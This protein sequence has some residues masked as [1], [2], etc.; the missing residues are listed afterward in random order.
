MRRPIRITHAHTS[1]VALSQKRLP[2][3]AGVDN[4]LC[5]SPSVTSCSVDPWQPHDGSLGTIPGF[6]GRRRLQSGLVD[7]FDIRNELIDW[8]L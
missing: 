1:V 8:C 7:T 2:I 6:W 5:V 3:A 4:N